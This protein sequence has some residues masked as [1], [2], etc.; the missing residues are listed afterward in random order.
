MS[1]STPKNNDPYKNKKQIAIIGSGAWASVIARIIA[2]N[3]LILK[4]FHPIVKMF[5]YDE[6]INNK[7]LSDIINETHENVKYAPGYIFTKNLKAIPDLVECVKFAD[8]L[9]FVVPRQYVENTCKTIVG[10]VKPNAV[11]V[12]LTK[13]FEVRP[14][15]SLWLISHI[16][17]KLLNIKC[18]VF[19]GANLAPE[20]A[21]EQKICR[22]T[23][24]CTHKTWGKWLKEIFETD[25]LKI[26]VVDDE[27]TVEACGALKN[28]VATAVGLMDG[29]AQ[30][31]HYK[32][33]TMRLG[34]IEMIKFVDIF[35]PGG[36]LST[37]FES[38][39][40]EDL[41][42]TSYGGRN[43]KCAKEMVVTGKKLAQIEEEMLKGQKLQ[44]PDTASQVCTMLRA[45]KMTH[46]FPFFTKVHAVCNG[47][48]PPD[49][50]KEYVE[51]NMS[52][53]TY[54]PVNLII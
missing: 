7:K 46:K 13:G 11:A 10:N 31:N 24:G 2:R 49:S 42:V 8:I 5:V 19:M 45:H 16:I 6:I 52:K 18:H 38:C 39:G 32:E 17:T 20:V 21:A 9:V 51:K 48:E 28:I 53:K 35:Y 22:S 54:V 50:L 30:K 26:N 25:H 1:S 4:R 40:I 27:D 29:L 33:A 15:G 37:F 36:K 14:G 43:S 34:F 3:V 41:I 44:G 23:L 47:D 12:S